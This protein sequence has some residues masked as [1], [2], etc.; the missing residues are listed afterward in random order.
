MIIK[1]LN[2]VRFVF[3]PVL[4]DILPEGSFHGVQE[5]VQCWDHA[6]DPQ[7]ECPPRLIEGSRTVS[8]TFASG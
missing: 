7:H 5:L 8:M 1:A 3:E 4:K 6:R 2:G